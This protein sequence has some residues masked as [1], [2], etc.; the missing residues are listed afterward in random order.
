MALR[1]TSQPRLLVYSTET[2]GRGRTFNM[3]E[4]VA[5]V[6]LGENARIHIGLEIAGHDNHFAIEPNKF[7]EPLLS[8]RHFGFFLRQ[9]KVY[10]SDRGSSQ[11]TSV[12]GRPISRATLLRHGDVI[13]PGKHYVTHDPMVGIVFDANGGKFYSRP[14]DIYALLTHMARKIR[15]YGKK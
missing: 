1:R 8:A 4:K 15:R 14:K 13:T 12:N 6:P 5:V 7:I 10:V 11:G 3:S 9:G 2:T